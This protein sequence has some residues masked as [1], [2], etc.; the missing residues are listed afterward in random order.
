MQALLPLSC[1]FLVTFFI[2]KWQHVLQTLTLCVEF[3][4][5]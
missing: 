2:Y 3:V 1:H 5:M 4:H